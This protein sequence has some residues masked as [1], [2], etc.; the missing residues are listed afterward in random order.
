MPQ[1][2]IISIGL[3]LYFL[4][5]INATKKITTLTMNEYISS[6]GELKFSTFIKIKAAEANNPT[7]AGRKPL[8]TASTIGC[9]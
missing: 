5:P 6:L 7:T 1:Q 3:I 8:K 4:V 2:N 9:F